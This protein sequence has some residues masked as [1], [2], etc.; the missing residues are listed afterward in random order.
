MG[1]LLGGVRPEL[2]D[3]GLHEPLLAGAAAPLQLRLD[4]VIVGPQGHPLGPRKIYKVPQMA[5]KLRN[6]GEIVPEEGGGGVEEGVAVVEAHNAPGIGHGPDLPVG[7]VPG[8]VAQRPAAGVG[9]EE[10]LF[11]APGHVPEAPL[12]EVRH[13]HGDAQ[14]VHPAHALQPEG[15]QP[16]GVEGRVPVLRVA[17]GVLPVPGE[18]HHPHALFVVFIHVF[19]LSCQRHAVL[20]REDGAHLSRPLVLQ[21]VRGG[22]GRGEGVPAKRQLPEIGLI[23]GVK[24]R[25]GRSQLLRRV[26]DA[27][28]GDEDRKALRHGLPG[29]QPLETDVGAGQPVQMLPGGKPHHGVTVKVDDLH[30]QPSNI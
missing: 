6:G 12:A 24:I 11:G 19:K 16:Q 14:L 26:R 8:D 20:H 30:T 18:G 10:G 5:Q 7:E 29:G 27:V 4:A 23:G 25:P 2:A 1:D 17:Q 22:E 13:V 28:G 21:D 9:G 15:L 3:D